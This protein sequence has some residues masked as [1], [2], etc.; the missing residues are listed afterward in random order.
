PSRINP[1]RKALARTEAPAHF[2]L[3]VINVSVLANLQE[4]N[5][6]MKCSLEGGTLAQVDSEA[7][8]NYLY[9]LMVN[10]GAWIGLG[11]AE[12]ENTFKWEGSQQLATYTNWDTNEPN[13]GGAESKEEDCVAI[14]P[15]TEKWNDYNCKSTINYFCE[16]PLSNDPCIE[17]SCKNG[18][19][20]TSQSGSYACT[21]TSQF[22][23]KRCEQSCPSGWSLSSGRCYIFK[24]ASVNWSTAKSKCALEGGTLV[25]I[26]SE[27]VNDYLYTLRSNE[28][29]ETEEAWIGLGDAETKIHSN[30][31]TRN[32][33]PH[34]QIGEQMNRI[35]AQDLQTM[36]Q[37]LQTKIVLK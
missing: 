6:S 3:A 31:T 28:G 12:S 32:N 17:S 4:L 2:I 10:T 35:M 29:H 1:A 11:D 16:R 21:C 13:N 20:C 36:A 5:V 19:T 27:A 37:E 9:T 22:A 24:R 14:A 15:P 30:G 26:D 33:L 18:G 23:G 34:I 8:N 7:V 25:Q